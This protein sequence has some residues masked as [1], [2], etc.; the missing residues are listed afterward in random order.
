MA[1]TAPELAFLTK[2]MAGLWIG[3]EPVDSNNCSKSYKREQGA[4]FALNKIPVFVRK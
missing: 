3:I 4:D 2:D 1:L